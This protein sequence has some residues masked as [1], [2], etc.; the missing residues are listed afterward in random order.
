MPTDSLAALAA[1]A[2]DLQ[3]AGG[4][5]ARR[6]T[7][8]TMGQLKRVSY[9]HDHMID[10]MISQ[11]GISQAQISAYFGYSQSWFSNILA[12]DAFQARLAERRKE[13]IDPMMI[14]TIEERFRALTIQSLDRLQQKLEAPVVS[15]QVL[16]RAA[17]LGAKALGI[18]GNAAPKT[19]VVD[20]GGLR[21][22]LL[23]LRGSVYEGTAVQIQEN[24]S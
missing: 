11:P 6:E 19:V 2:Q 24:G 20:L 14:A 1:V 17:E 23:A 9:T 7:A 10:L 18:G 4:A 16:I 22:R 5:P 21:D 12:S 8:P 15:D 3:D 13:V